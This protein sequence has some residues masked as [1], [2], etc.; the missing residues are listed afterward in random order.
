M[1]VR[2]SIAP[3]AVGIVNKEPGL[4]DEVIMVIGEGLQPTR[5]HLNAD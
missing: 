2:A 5:S 3:V 4:T 1:M